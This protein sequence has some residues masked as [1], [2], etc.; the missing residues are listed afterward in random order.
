MRITFY[1]S[2]WP[3]DHERSSGLV[4]IT[5]DIHSALQE[6]GHNRCQR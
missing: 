3:L 1:P 6:E 5:R 4:L 2:F